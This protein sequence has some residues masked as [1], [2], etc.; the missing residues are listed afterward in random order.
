[1]LDKT[2]EQEITYIYTCL[3]QK[4][5]LEETQATYEYESQFNNYLIEQSDG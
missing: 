3:F 4:F 2:P 5:L 1:M